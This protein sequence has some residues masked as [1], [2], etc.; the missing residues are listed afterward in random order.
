MKSSL[1][2]LLLAAS[3]INAHGMWQKLRVN[4][5]DQGQ[6]VAIR[7]PSSNYPI[8]QVS[9]S[10]IAC[11]SG[12][13]NPVSTAVVRVPAGARVGSW[14]Q[15]VIGGAQGPYD[16]DNPIA[17]SHKGPITVYLAK[18]DN[19][20]TASNYNALSWFKVAEE[21]LNTQTSKWAVDSMIQG[22]GWWDFTMPSCVAPGQY[23]MRIELLALHSAY[24]VNG[25]QF[26]VS[27]ANIEVTGSGTST[28]TN[29]V[30]FP[31]AY[32]SNDPGIQI[33]IYAGMPSQPNN[34]NKPYPIPGPK[35][36][37]C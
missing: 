34:G 19:A 32:Q 11:N 33:N 4:G 5:V 31:G 12:L 25:A 22:Q 16:P 27:C 26:Y 8:Q 2:S 1:L 14:F 21:G 36:L 35:P 24:S 37:M 28:G 30:R 7:P 10:A 20:G 9:S 17:S 3:S 13:R 29:M 15:H 23:L 18:V 6:N